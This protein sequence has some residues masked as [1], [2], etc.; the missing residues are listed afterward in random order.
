[1]FEIF[2]EFD[3]M[4]ENFHK[5]IEE[6]NGL[7]TFAC[8]FKKQR[9]ELEEFIRKHPDAVKRSSIKVIWNSDMDEPEITIKGDVDEKVIENIK[10]KFLE[11]KKDK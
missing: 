4:F 5:I 8:S 1:M 10:K 2:K 11:Y 6:T 7:I 3:K 9:K